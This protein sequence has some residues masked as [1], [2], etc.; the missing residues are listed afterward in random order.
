MANV[1]TGRLQLAEALERQVA[2]LPDASISAVFMTGGILTADDV[3]AIKEAARLC[4]VAVAIAIEKPLSPQHATIAEEAGA[5]IIYTHKP[6]PNIGVGCT[7]RQKGGG[8]ITL[9]L[10]ALL[11]V[12]PSVVVASADNLNILRIAK[13]LGTTFNNFFGVIETSTPAAV[14]SSR[15]QELTA[16]L[17]FA[18]DVLDQGERRPQVVMQQVVEALQQNG[19]A[20]V[21][22]LLLLDAETLG[23]VQTR[24]PKEVFLYADIAEGEHTLRRSVKLSA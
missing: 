3:V 20:D 21:K 14:L 13:A 4:D 18:Q 15:Q 11:L 17:M 5:N 8:D 1:I 19:F 22:N 24:I 10:E 2:G 6:K 9:F 7:V 16:T 23:E 12:M